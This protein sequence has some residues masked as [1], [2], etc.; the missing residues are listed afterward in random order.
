MILNE[1][2]LHVKQS[3]SLCV[4]ECFALWKVK[5]LSAENT[6][7]NLAFQSERDS[8]QESK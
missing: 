6:T 8:E 3:R 1:H 7:V 2:L 4:Y 5:Y